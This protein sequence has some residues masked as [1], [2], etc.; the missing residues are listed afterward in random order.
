MV[1]V[2]MMLIILHQVSYTNIIEFI[3]LTTLVQISEIMLRIE[4][5]WVESMK[6]VT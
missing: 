4:S 1:I 3:R 5:S 2:R 6:D